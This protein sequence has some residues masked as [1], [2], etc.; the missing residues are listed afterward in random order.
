MGIEEEKQEQI[1]QEKREQIE[2]ERLQKIE[3]EKIAQREAER[4]RKEQIEKDRLEKMEQQRIE[5][6]KEN[7]FNLIKQQQA[8]QKKEKEENNNLVVPVSNI[9]V[10]V[11]NMTRSVGTGNYP[12]SPSSVSSSN[13]DSD[14]DILQNDGFEET[15]GG[16]NDID[17]DE[18][19]EDKDKNEEAVQENDDEKICD[20]RHNAEKNCTEFLVED[21]EGTTSWKSRAEVQDFEFYREYCRKRDIGLLSESDGDNNDK[22]SIVECDQKGENAVDVMKQV[23]NEMD[24]PYM[25]IGL[26]KS[27][28]KEM[29]HIKSPKVEHVEESQCDD[30][31]KNDDDDKDKNEE[32]ES[33]ESVL[34][35]IDHHETPQ[36]PEDEIQEQ[37]ENMSC[38][39]EEIAKKVE[40]NAENEEDVDVAAEIVSKVIN[41]ENQSKDEAKDE[42]VSDDKTDNK[43]DDENL[44]SV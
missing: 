32:N 31:K 25:D 42:N 2:R 41:M 40:S 27:T 7:E 15:K 21:K 35:D 10:R 5:E 36:N 19:D 34:S 20:Y 38:N 18:N 11:D 24:N 17:I 28:Y 16:P 26:M 22:Q 43:N 6:Q 23:E 13:S 4:L 14:D 12:S 39:E 3:N 33:T 44:N 1:E 29:Q 30:E 8:K 9:D 37:N